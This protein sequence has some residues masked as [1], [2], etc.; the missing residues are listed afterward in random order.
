[1]IGLNAFA[2]VSSGDGLLRLVS[3]WSVGGVVE[4]FSPWRDI[5]Q[6]VRIRRIRGDILMQGELGGAFEALGF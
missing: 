4:V 2:L 3:F 6:P 1:M 5:K